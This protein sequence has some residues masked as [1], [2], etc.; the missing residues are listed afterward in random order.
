MI[1]PV[2]NNNVSISK[3]KHKAQPFQ[4]FNL[5]GHTLCYASPPNDKICISTNSADIHIDKTYENIKNSLCVITAKDIENITEKIQLE[6]G[7]LS[8]EEIFSIMNALSQYGSYNSI[9]DITEELYAKNISEIFDFAALYMYRDK[10]IKEKNE[11]PFII[12]NSGLKIPADYTSRIVTTIPKNCRVALGCILDYLT[13][14]KYPLNYDTK[15]P[16]LILDKNA[17]KLFQNLKKSDKEFFNNEILNNDIFIPVYI[18]NFDNS[19]NFLNQGQTFEKAVVHFAKK[20]QKLKHEHPD[21]CPERIIDILFNAKNL[22]SIKA[23]GFSPIRINPDKNREINAQTIARNL[24]P[25]MPS[26]ENFRN[27]IKNICRQSPDVPANILEDLLLQY[28]DINLAVYSPVLLSKKLKTLHKKIVESVKA[29]GY[30]EENIYY[31]VLNPD[32]SFGIISYQ[33]QNVNNIP[34]DKMIY[35]RGYSFT[36][37]TDL[38]LPEKSTIVILDDCFI[39][40][41]TIMYEIFNYQL[42][43]NNLNVQRDGTNILFASVLSTNIAENRIKNNIRYANREKHDDIISVDKK[44]IYWCDNIKSKYI[45][46][47]LKLMRRDNHILATTAVVFP[48]MG[49]DT[50]A[51]GLR[52][53][54]AQFVPKETFLHNEL[55][56]DDFFMDY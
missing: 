38:Y 49:S 28:L 51:P 3:Y 2:I 9:K 46:D 14:L 16:A 54:F 29:K 26:K 1:L 22:K 27:I 52:E 44:D 48:F 23:L 13:F 4:T 53:L 37:K 40:G 24:A 50:N 45:T 47:L 21:F 31:T 43:A 17:I 20:Y 18:D 15:K 34:D 19:Y 35:W 56:E 42:E 39:S 32:K 5:S 33:F 7:N 6:F 11:N 41:N 30:P 36:P 55:K 8:K 10:L 12:H 25:V